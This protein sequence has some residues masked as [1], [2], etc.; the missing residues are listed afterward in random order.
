MD[1]TRKTMI[2]NND[3]GEMIFDE[4]EQMNLYVFMDGKG[5][6]LHSNRIVPRFAF[7]REWPVSKMDQ[8]KLFFLAAYINKDNA[9][10]RKDRP[11]HPLTMQLLA[12]L[13]ELSPNRAY[14]WM[15][16][17][18]DAN[19]I[20]KDDG[21]FYVNPLY[22]MASSRLGP[23]LYRIFEDQLKEHTPSWVQDKYKELKSE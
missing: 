8:A 19:M 12:P 20:R 21:F 23:E 11:K 15:K 3:T 14:G 17:M 5:Y 4:E 7:Y 18:K 6:L 22:V 10:M 16:R 13:I 2:I 9:L 1:A